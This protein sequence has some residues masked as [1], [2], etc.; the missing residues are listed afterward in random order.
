MNV[1]DRFLE[2]VSID[3]R[4][5]DQSEE[6]PSTSGQMFL[7][8]LLYD[9]LKRIG[10]QEVEVDD[11][12]YV[13]ATLPSN[14]DGKV[15]VIGFIAH[16]D[17][18][19][20]MSGK[21]VKPQI[22]KNYDGRDIILDKKNN[23]I[24]KPDDFPE[25][26]KYIGQDIITTCGHTLLGADDKA[27]I[28]EIVSAMEF[29]IQNPSVKHGKIRV[30][31]TPDEEIGRGAN[32]FDIRKFGADFAY[33]MD[34]GEIGELEYENFNAAVALIEIQGRNVH[35]G[36]AF[37][38]M[39]NSIEIAGRIISTLPV[40]ESPAHTKDYDGFYHV[41]SVNGEV[42]KTEIEILIRDFDEENFNSRKK[43]LENL[44]SKINEEISI[45]P[46]K[47][48]IED[49]YQNMRK[50]IEP[51]LHV[52]ELAKKAM[53]ESGI[54][55]I[56]RPIRGGTDGARLSYMRLPTPNIF[57]GGHNFHGRYEFIPVQSMQKA[58]EVI[59]K[60]AELAIN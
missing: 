1:V 14:F 51:V 46:V 19:P 53:L 25:L 43:Y 16:M 9:E 38:K 26:I 23:I 15:P 52:V 24:L 55:P 35:P 36:Y 54:K 48:K 21:N 50:Q 13:M 28:A 33:T 18:S 44:V 58:V 60:I 7:A 34:G 39:V 22:V 29:L 40:S 45:K 30:C 4:S 56:I 17:T 5:D 12:G 6:C 32:K 20:D 47:L 49:Q 27:G 31:F 57:A 3:T 41:I 37:K 11:N 2:Y 59:V 42:E 8:R 10:M